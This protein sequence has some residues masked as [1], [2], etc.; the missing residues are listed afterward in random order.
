[1]KTIELTQGQVAIIDDEDFD[2]VNQFK[3]TAQKIVHKNKT[4]RLLDILA[5]LEPMVKT[6]KESLIA[7]K[8]KLEK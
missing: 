5:V 7:H 2:L 4:D 8:A 1:M 6:S 3:W